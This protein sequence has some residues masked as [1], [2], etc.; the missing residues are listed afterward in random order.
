MC[1]YRQ[2]APQTE[3]VYFK[4]NVFSLISIIPKYTKTLPCPLQYTNPQD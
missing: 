4:Y 3:K 1:K 2:S